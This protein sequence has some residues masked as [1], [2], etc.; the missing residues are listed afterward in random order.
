MSLGPPKP[1]AGCGKVKRRTGDYCRE[2]LHAS[3]Q[4][5]SR[6]HVYRIDETAALPPGRWV[7]DRHGIYRFQA[8]ERQSQEAS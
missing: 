5:H 8:A 3:I 7:H 4:T 1:C 2:C 6:N